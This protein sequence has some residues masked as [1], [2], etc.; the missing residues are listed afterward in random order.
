MTKLERLQAIDPNVLQNFIKTKKSAAIAEDLQEYII[1]MNSTTSIIHHNG[2]SQTRVCKALM[3]EFSDI[4]YSQARDIYYDALNFFYVDDN[5]SAAAW[6]NY[7]AEKFED[8]SRLAI[9]AD[10]LP[11]AC[12]AMANAHELRT[13]N[14]DIIKPTDWAPAI[15]IINPEVDPKDLGYKTKSIYEIQRRRENKMLGDMIEDLPTSEKNKTKLKEEA[16]I[17][18]VEHE[19]VNDDTGE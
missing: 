10:N 6:D 19:E 2:S 17:Q 13:K 3:L 11:V 1:R 4:T 9:V 5:I 18:D 8:L 12:K 15:F 16:G 7:Y 14:R